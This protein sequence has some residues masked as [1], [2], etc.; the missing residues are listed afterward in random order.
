MMKIDK[1]I[2]QYEFKI[3]VYFA[4]IVFFLVFFLGIINKVAF[5]TII[6]R[7]FI[8][9]IFFIPLGFFI[10]YVIKPIVTNAQQNVSNKKENTNNDEVAQIQEAANIKDKDVKKDINSQ[11]MVD[12]IINQ[13]TNSHDISGLSL[14]TPTSV[15]SENAQS[16]IVNLNKLTK[17]S[18]GKHMIIN[19]KKIINDP[20]IMEAAIRTMINKED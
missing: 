18:L 9:E 5:G 6:S 10:G 12:D 4:A 8:S 11:N 3:A 16:D 7:I 13:T 17:K 1:I 19:D 2:K 14:N 20:E 15:R